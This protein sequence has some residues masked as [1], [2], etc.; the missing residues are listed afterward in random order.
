MSL[1]T[2]NAFRF[3]AT[4][5]LI[6]RRHLRNVLACWL[7]ACSS[8]AVADVIVLAN[9]TGRA[10][11][12]R[13]APLSGSPQML[14]LAAGENVPIYLDGKAN[15]SVSS[16]G[17]PNN[18][19][20]DANCAYFFAR[21]N[22]GRI[23][24]QKI[25][26]GEDGTLTD[27]HA[28]P[29]TASRAPIATVTVKILVDEEEPGRQPIW[30]RRLRRRVEAASAVFEKYFRTKL[31]I[32]AVG[33]WNSDNSTTDFI[34]SLDEFE[35]EVNPAPAKL[36]IG[37]TSQW[38]MT[39]GRTHMA[40]TRGPLH[41]HIL[42][43]EGSPQIS[44]A[45]K[46]EF[47]IHEL[48]H[49]FGAAHSPERNS[50]MR[51]VLGDNR[52]GS[53]GYKIQFDPVN[54]LAMAIISDEMR[55]RNLTQLGELA[56]ETRRRLGQIYM[57]LARSLPDD[58]AALGY[59]QRVRSE[60]STPLAIATRSVVKAIIHAA[61]DNRALPIARS[62]LSTMES[63]RQGDE[64]TNYLVREAARTAVDLP[65]PDRLQAFLYGV[66]I[67]LSDNDLLTNFPAASGIVSA[68]EPPS[69]RMIRLAVLG[70]PT[71][72]GRRDLAQH[73]LASV[74]ATAAAGADAA[75]AAGHAKELFDSR[76]A[77]GFSFADIAAN[78]AGARFASSVL[79]QRMTLGNLRLAF[80]V[81]SYMPDVT[82]LPEHI[83]AKD[84]AAQFGSQNDLRFTKQ[85]KEIDE[86]IRK[87]PAYA[88]AKPT[89][90][91]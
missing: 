41:S 27:G 49:Y 22:S 84:F 23:D 46:L 43:R 4:R 81:T 63:R 53:A 3:E 32:V 36:A 65:E 44:E 52:A 69:E 26:L 72:R 80:A 25:G 76:R 79:E 20:L 66:A 61:I 90:N 58:A 13:F 75:N 12:V 39:R 7:I 47:L 10:L 42:A 48:G 21:D 62:S 89:A 77:S 86:R 73:F 57:E 87:L 28:L 88:L 51:P 31:E 19:L 30:E 33:T 1:Q 35:R 18:R 16:P 70:E 15:I 6:R 68:V 2:H 38:Q 9:R 85:L 83:A 67:G 34:A 50:V 71:M 82:G 74:F 8:S 91:P 14:T 55:R 29:G 78:R 24:V 40:G 17:A 59:A 54:M 11:P 45:E 60:S 37:F 5:T 56:P 64:L